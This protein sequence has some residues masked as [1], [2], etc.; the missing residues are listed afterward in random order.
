MVRFS[1]ARPGF[2]EYSQVNLDF[3]LYN[4]IMKTEELLKLQNKWVAFS[5][6]RK[7]IVVK[8]NSLSKLL[9][10]IGN[11]RNLIVSFVNPV[12]KYLSP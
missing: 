7:K 6:D 10:K 8:S 11:K 4:K 3:L 1:S 2:R 9:K 12:D 5:Q